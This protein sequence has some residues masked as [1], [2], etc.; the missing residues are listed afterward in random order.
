MDSRQVLARFDAE[1]QALAVMVH[2]HIARVF[3][4][5]VTERGRPFF[6]MEYIK[7]VPLTEYCDKAQ[8]NLL[9]R[10]LP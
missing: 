3:D 6:A 8:L 2:P 7:G 9:R 5:G 10:L 4:G 1:R